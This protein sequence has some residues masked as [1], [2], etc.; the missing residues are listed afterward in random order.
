MF[1]FGFLICSISIVPPIEAGKKTDEAKESL[2][3]KRTVWQQEITSKKDEL[4]RKGVMRKLDFGFSDENF[5]P[6]SVRSLIE[7][8]PGENPNTSESLDK[9]GQTTRLPKP[10]LMR[11]RKA[12]RRHKRK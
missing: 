10:N 11:K 12:I 9:S 3:K 6:N 1:L 5:Q 8:C 4:K 7:F 2:M